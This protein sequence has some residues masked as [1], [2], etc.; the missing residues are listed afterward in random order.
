MKTTLLTFAI[1]LATLS[2]SSFALAEEVT[3]PVI[4]R[5]NLLLEGIQTS[6]SD[7]QVKELL[8]W[9]KNSKVT[10]SE[11][12]ED[13]HDLS[14]NDKIQHLN[15]GVI[16][17][18]SQSTPT[19]ELFMRYILNRSLVLLETLKNETD[20]RSVGVSDVKLRILTASIKM[21][22]KYQDK[23]TRMLSNKSK[24][25]FASFGVN[26]FNFLL[27]LNK[28]IFDASAQYKI[29]QISLEW[30]AWDLYRDLDSNSYAAQIVKI[31]KFVKA[32]PKGSLTDTQSMVYIRKMRDLQEKLNV[33]EI[34][35][36]IE[37]KSS[38]RELKVSERVLTLNR[39]TGFLREA[40]IYANVSDSAVG[41]E[42]QGSN[43]YYCLKYTDTSKAERILG[44]DNYIKR[45]DILMATGCGDKFCVG[46][47]VRE[48][49]SRDIFRII[50]IDSNGDYALR[51][52]SREMQG[53]QDKD[54][55][56]I[57]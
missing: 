8:P 19:S 14:I 22:I 46:E 47:E 56:K 9:A 48:N 11:L 6:L 39:A 12:L 35:K 26:Y 24:M 51:S 32:L 17:V 13:V 53:L 20:E 54:L 21:A 16:D 34:I 37:D 18:V 4:S 29:H 5:P 15:D 44:Y 3:L 25:T 36:K 50:G 42:E 33:S 28:S 1:A 10:L 49:K 38:G 2:T 40:I 31:H 30:L 23:D 27:D 45:T 43:T 55:E 41:N 7:A 52:G 57:K